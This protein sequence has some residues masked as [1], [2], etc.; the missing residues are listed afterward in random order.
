MLII[1]LPFS[2]CMIQ[3]T[4]FWNQLNVVPFAGPVIRSR[5]LCFFCFVLQ[6]FQCISITCLKILHRHKSSHFHSMRKT[7]TFYNWHTVRAYNSIEWTQMKGNSQANEIISVHPLNRCHFT[8][9]Y[10]NFIH[11]FHTHALGMS[12]KLHNKLLI[13]TIFGI[14]NG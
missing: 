9:M 3:L 4:G 11:A 8:S 5:F 1:L 6:K 10:L 2:V 12:V 13:W 14:M 7:I